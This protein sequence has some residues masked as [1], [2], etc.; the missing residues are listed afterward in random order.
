MSSTMVFLGLGLTFMI[1]PLYTLRLITEGL[2]PNT[3]I[4]TKFLPVGPCGQV[5]HFGEYMHLRL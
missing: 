3:L 5:R 2:P 1:L 4:T